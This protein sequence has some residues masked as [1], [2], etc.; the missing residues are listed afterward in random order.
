MKAIDLAQMAILEMQLPSAR[1][2]GKL[3]NF[4]VYKYADGYKYDFQPKLMTVGRGSLCFYRDQE[5]TEI[6][7]KP[8]M[9]IHLDTIRNIRSFA[10][11]TSAESYKNLDSQGKLF[12][13]IERPTDLY[14]NMIEIGLDY[15]KITW[16]KRSNSLSQRGEF[17]KTKLLKLFNSEFDEMNMFDTLYKKAV[18]QPTLSHRALRATALTQRR[19]STSIFKGKWLSLESRILLACPTKKQ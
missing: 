17:G 15:E 6:K 9:E 10:I 18:D 12:K 3:K 16:R 4:K 11:K 13:D 2:T 19:R 1:R 5:G 8:L 14:R 7:N